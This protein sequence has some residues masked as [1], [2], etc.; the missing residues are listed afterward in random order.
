MADVD[1]LDDRVIII[2]CMVAV[3]LLVFTVTRERVDKRAYRD[4][5]AFGRPIPTRHYENATKKKIKE[6]LTSF[7][8]G[9]YIG[10]VTGGGIPAA[11]GSGFTFVVMPM[12]F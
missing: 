1:K 4:A 11:L 6:C 7:A 8:K 5:V 9:C 3:V 10:M 12:I 2:S